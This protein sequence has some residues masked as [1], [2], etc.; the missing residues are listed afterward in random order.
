[1]KITVRQKT[2]QFEIENFFGPAY[3]YQAHEGEAV[4]LNGDI[5][6]PFKL[7]YGA[8]LLHNDNIGF[9]FKDFLSGVDDKDVNEIMQYVTSRIQTLFTDKEQEQEKTEETEPGED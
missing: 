4:T 2:Y 5:L 8:L 9:G 7:V 3:M 6:A 1:M